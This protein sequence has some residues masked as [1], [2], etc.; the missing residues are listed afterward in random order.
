M[1]LSEH[2]NSIMPLNSPGG[3]TLQ[4]DTERGLMSPAPFVSS[5]SLFT[6]LLANSSYNFP[7]LE[8]GGYS[9]IWYHPLKSKFQ[10]KMLL[11]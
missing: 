9:I 2:V 5:L 1:K 3:S 10:M 4:H 8:T 11:I 6:A 7:V